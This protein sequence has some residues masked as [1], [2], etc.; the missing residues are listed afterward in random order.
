MDIDLDEIEEF[1]D[2]A[3]MNVR[4]YSEEFEEYALTVMNRRA[5]S[6]PIDVKQA[7]NLYIELLR[8]IKLAS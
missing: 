6:A 5:L 4:D 3:A 8:E 7:F 2:D 1:Y